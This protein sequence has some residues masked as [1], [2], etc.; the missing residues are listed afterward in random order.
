MR[1]DS[2]TDTK[3]KE[4]KEKTL[5]SEKNE[6]LEKEQSVSEKWVM[7]VEMDDGDADY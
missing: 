7:V 2:T 1:L 3:M 6:I 5:I 4:N